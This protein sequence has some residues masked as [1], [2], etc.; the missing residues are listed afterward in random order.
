MKSGSSDKGKQVSPDDLGRITVAMPVSTRLTS[1]MVSQDPEAVAFLQ[2]AGD[3]DFHVVNFACT[4]LDST[5]APF[6][7]AWLQMALSTV[8]DA[9]SG[10]PI[11]WSMKP[12]RE[13]DLVTSSYSVKL[14]GKLKL[15]TGEEPGVAVEVGD[16]TSHEIGFITAYNLMQSRPYWRFRRT[17]VRNIDGSYQLSLVVR[18]PRAKEVKGTLA[19]KATI[20]KKVAW[21]LPKREATDAPTLSFDIR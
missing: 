16:Q 14:E 18:R 1:N 6:E 20:R 8:T 2:S 15:S 7:E 10:E 9:E 4:F 13:A 21:F 19:V 3:D 11:A 5:V 17:P 12:E